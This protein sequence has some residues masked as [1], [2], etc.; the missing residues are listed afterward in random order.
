MVELI[1]IIDEFKADDEQRELLIKIDRLRKLSRLRGIRNIPFNNTRDALRLILRF[2]RETK[3]LQFRLHDRMYWASVPCKNVGEMQSI[4]A[5][6][7][8]YI[9]KE[10]AKG[11]KFI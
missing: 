3:E 11:T 6:L 9:Q 10:K 1:D 4:I 8:A 7:S 2:Y 5:D